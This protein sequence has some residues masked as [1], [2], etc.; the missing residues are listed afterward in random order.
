MTIPKAGSAW[1][2]TDGEGWLLGILFTAIVD[3]ENFRE[4]A[5]FICNWSYEVEAM[6]LNIADQHLFA[7]WL[8]TAF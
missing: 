1:A 4:G 6:A 7:L 8:H 3:T 5:S 2:T